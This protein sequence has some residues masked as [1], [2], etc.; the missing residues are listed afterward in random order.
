MNVDAPVSASAMSARAAALVL[1]AFLD[2]NARFSD[3]TRRAQ[4]WFEH[5]NWKQAQIDRVWRMDLY[6]EC[7]AETLAR[8]EILLDDRIRARAL[9]AAMRTEYEALV[10]PLL[11]REL[12][13]TFFNSL[14]R[15]FFHTV[16]VDS[17]IE[18]IALDADPFAGVGAPVARSEYAAGD[19]L[20]AS[21]RRVLE[22]Y[23][24]RIGYADADADAAAI[25]RAL[26]ERFAIPGGNAILRIEFLLTRFFRERRAYLVGR[27]LAGRAAS[28][29]QWTPLVIA[30][31][32]DA[33][34]IRVDAVLTDAGQV[35]ALFGF[36]RSYF[37]ADLPG[38]GDAVAFL[39]ALMPHKP[40]GELYTV[41]GRA[42][43]GKTERY[44]ALFRHLAQHPDERIVRA[45]GARGMVMAVLTPAGYPVVVKVIRD[46]FA[47]PKDS[48]RRMVEEKYR[49]VFRYDRVGRLVDAQEFR[50]LRFPARQFDAG[51]LAELLG[52]CAETV[53]LE[54]EDV[55][56]R[57][58]Y[59]ERRLRP[60]NLYAREQPYEAASAA[61][62]DYGQAIKDLALSNIFPGD[63]LLKNFGVSSRGRAIFYDYDE[64][65]LVEQ[66]RFRK[67]PEAR[68]DDETRPIEDWLSV[69]N[70]D[71]FPELFARF[72]GLPDGLRN[73]LV[74]AHAEIFD[75]AWW[76]RVQVA[77]ARGEIADIPP[78]PASARVGS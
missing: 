31:V 23:A 32:N 61:V 25:A 36:S 50:H 41:L 29:A 20:R 57:H 14:S 12:F 38:I 60:L 18:F 66:C 44:R 72:L 70:D 30:L 73:A 9:W 78:Y 21:C 3:I 62:I 37:L 71:V 47:Y 69:R 4:R 52:E 6:D 75:A 58:C 26:E 19:E 33:G 59:I 17:G 11:D 67:I 42:K 16:G 54:G 5:R 7:M 55:L 10:E 43:Q 64:L 49:L 1:D 46:Q 28:G 13:K 8:L 40:V 27:L 35:S 2:Y 15:R 53:S 24:F 65:C 56:I 63:L 39:H 68:E 48:A 77:L 34:R 76:Q 45:D 74:A 22:D 51:L